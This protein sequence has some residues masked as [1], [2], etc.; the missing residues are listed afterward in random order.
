MSITDGQ[1]VLRP[2][3]GGPESPILVDP[4]LSVSRIGSRA[5][6]QALED[7]ATQIRSASPQTLTPCC[8][9]L[10]TSGH[11]LLAEVD[12]SAGP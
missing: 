6:P 3:Q 4:R 10:G 8:L 12:W 2:R 9:P 5:Y 7:L 1:V 11:H